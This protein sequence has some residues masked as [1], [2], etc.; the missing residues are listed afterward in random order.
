[1]KS[2]K[3]RASEKSLGSKSIDKKTK[4]TKKQKSLIGLISSKVLSSEEKG[5]KQELEKK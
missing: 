5:D 3:S 1:M 2:L 4:L